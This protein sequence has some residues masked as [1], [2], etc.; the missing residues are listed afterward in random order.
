MQW[1][2]P[3]VVNDKQSTASQFFQEPGEAAIGL[4]QIELTEELGSVVVEGAESLPAG[5]V[6]QGT[7]QVRFADPGGTGNEAVSL[8]A[9]PLA[10]GQLVDGGAFEPARMAEVDVLEAGGLFE[11]GVSQAG[12]QGAVFLPDSLAFHQKGQSLVE[13]QVTAVGLLPLFLPGVGHAVEL[14]GVEFFHG[15]F[16]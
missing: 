13:A 11:V 15:L 4:R 5:F 6:R 16:G 9:D 3:P 7:G 2:Q 14:H 10:R 1:G 8:M 12:G